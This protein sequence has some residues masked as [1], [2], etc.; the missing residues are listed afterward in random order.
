LLTKGVVVPSTTATPAR[1]RRVAKKAAQAAKP[2]AKPGDPY[3]TRPWTASYP[4]GVPADYDFP[5]F[6]LTRLLDDSAGLFPDQVALAF[7]GAKTTYRELKDQVDRFAGA[8]AS[9]G[10]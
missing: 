9:R 1:S 2:K 4:D 6:A 5:S 10:G 8:L 3:S 7:L